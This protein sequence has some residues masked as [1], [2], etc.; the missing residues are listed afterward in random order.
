LNIL[1]PKEELMKVKV[2]ECDDESSDNEINPNDIIS[3]AILD[4][5][6]QHLP[7]NL[8]SFLPKLKY[9][10]I[11]DSKLLAISKDDLAGLNELIEITISGNG[12]TSIPADAFKELEQ[13]QIIDISNNAITELP[14]GIFKHA[15][16]RNVNVSYNAIA[17]LT[18]DLFAESNNI[19][20]LYFNAN[21][22]T[23]ISP[24]FFNNL[25]SIGIA[26]FSHNN[27]IKHKTP[28]D[29]KFI[30][31]KNAIAENC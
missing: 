3:L 25:N 1:L 16:L 2:N 27:C 22:I 29:M 21:K 20:E 8:A 17:K 11:R 23:K 12:L 10:V 24:K 31:L 5:N 18:D 4:Q 15:S 6:V 7:A 28:E 26:D 13:L 19:E 14:N 9:L 30:P